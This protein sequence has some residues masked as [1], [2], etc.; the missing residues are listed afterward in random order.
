MASKDLEEESDVGFS[1]AVV[2]K[3]R[4]RYLNRWATRPKDEEEVSDL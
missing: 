4:Q 3:T 1:N 2:S